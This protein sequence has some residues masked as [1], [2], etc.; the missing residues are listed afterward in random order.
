MRRRP[1]AFAEGMR[2]A[3]I[4]PTFK[5][6]PGLGRTTSNTDYSADVV[7]SEIDQNS[8]DVG[9]YRSLLAGGPSVVMVST[10]IYQKIDPS[11]PGGLL[12][13]CGHRSCCVARSG[14]AGVVMTD[15]LSATES[16]SG[17]DSRPARDHGDRRRMRRGA[18]VGR[19]GGGRE[20]CM[21]LCSR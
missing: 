3:G 14:Y 19:P 10:A 13:A 18:G 8:P 21:T 20:R 1:G 9:V 4:L 12:G 11:S 2:Q 16:V 5:H 15:D 17:V 7:D 6:F